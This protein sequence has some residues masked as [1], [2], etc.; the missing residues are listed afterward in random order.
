MIAHWPPKPRYEAEK[1]LREAINATAQANALADFMASTYA[2]GREAVER[3]QV[4]QDAVAKALADIDALR[5]TQTDN[6]SN[7]HLTNIR[8]DLAALIDESYR[9]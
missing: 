3:L 5:S 8:D 1:Q 2:S 9:P 7:T 4:M 6:V